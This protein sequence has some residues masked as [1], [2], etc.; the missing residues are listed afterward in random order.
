M[1]MFIHMFVFI[2]NVWYL[3]I[4]YI[5]IIFVFVCGSS[6]QLIIT[7]FKFVI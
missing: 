3:Y 1:Y 5:Y 7:S 4:I 6:N 2:L